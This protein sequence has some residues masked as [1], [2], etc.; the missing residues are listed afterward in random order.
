[1]NI[2]GEALRFA[3]ADDAADDAAEQVAAWFEY[4]KS[5]RRASAHTIEAYARDITQFCRFLTG[6][7][8]EPASLAALCLAQGVRFPRLSGGAAQ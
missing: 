3:A 7:L 5:E 8:G 6:H 4:L 2:D 1:M